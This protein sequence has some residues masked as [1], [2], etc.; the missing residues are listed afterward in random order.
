MTF[1]H[2]E[3]VGPYL[4]YVSGTEGKEVQTQ[5]YRG[6]KVKVENVHCT[7][8]QSDRW[9]RDQLHSLIHVES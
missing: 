5:I 1:V 7:R 6:S 8:N 9:V 3:K 4:V 2:S